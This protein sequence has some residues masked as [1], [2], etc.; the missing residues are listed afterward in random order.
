MS[1]KLAAF[2]PDA[3]IMLGAYVI[4]L[5][6]LFVAYHRAGNHWLLKHS[7]INRQEN[8]A[9]TVIRG[10]WGE[11]AV[12]T[13]ALAAGLVV[14]FFTNDTTLVGAIAAHPLKV[15]GVLAFVWIVIRLYTRVEVLR[16]EEAGRC[17]PYCR[18]LE[19]TYDVYNVFT[20]CI[21]GMGAM[22]IL[23][24]ATQFAHDAGV[25][26][27]EADQILAAFAEAQRMVATAAPGD[28]GVY[29]QA[30]SQAEEGFTRVA[31]ASKAL[32]SQ[33]N[34]LFIFAGTLI[35]IN[36]LIN[37]TSLKD[38]YTA[39]AQMLTAGF[40]YGPLLFIGFFGLLVY[41]NVYDVM[42]GEALVSLRAITPPPSLGNWEMAQ[43]HAE[44]VTQVSDARN[45]FGFATT[46]AGEGGGFAILAWGI[47]TALEKIKEAREDDE[48]EVPV[49]KP[50]KRFRPTDGR[51]T[52]ARARA[53]PRREKNPV[54]RMWTYL[55][56]G[57]RIP[58]QYLD[59]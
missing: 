49:K 58:P 51:P 14:I 41:L 48:D 45:I 1:S 52:S 13:M 29:A 18:R 4:A 19:R 23:M 32:Q 16:V 36:I 59:S 28:D 55:L 39:N 7:I 56:L 42:L 17:Q 30:M 43:R 54:R 5:L 12:A 35:A 2:L 9:R 26:R 20:F 47:Q 27:Y 38:M 15:A 3:S 53:R 6:A 40:T 57:R 25:F 33:F 21:F 37:L 31:L 34:P 50:G 10:Q 46:I 8:G 22:I 11:A 24:L 44:M